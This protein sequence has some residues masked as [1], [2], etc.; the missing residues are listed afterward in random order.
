M[1]DIGLLILRLTM[2]GVMLSHGLPKLMNYA[3]YSEKFPDPIGL[4]PTIS[5]IAAI[6]S[7]VFC[8]LLVIIGFKT[9]YVV[10]PLIVTMLV[11]FFI[12]HANDP[13][14]QKELAFLYLMGYIAIAFT[15][16]GKYSV[17]KN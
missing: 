13:F 5:L 1:R 4:G 8:S 11:A 3:E 10:A 14:Q 7:E 6:G 17:D 15:G 2:G 16:A 12:V 9:R